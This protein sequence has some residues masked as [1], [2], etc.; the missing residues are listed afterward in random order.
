LF[1][2]S[3]RRGITGDI[4][5]PVCFQVAGL[6]TQ[7]CKG[8]QI[9]DSKEFFPIPYQDWGVFFEETGSPETMQKIQGS[10][11]VH[12]WNKLSK[13]TAVIVGS[14]QPYNLMAERA[15]PRVYSACGRD[16]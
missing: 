7:S 4:H 12:V 14:K 3:S 9:L 11:G 15:C 16:L 8:F 1:E 10:F 2:S 5:T 13:H 6:S